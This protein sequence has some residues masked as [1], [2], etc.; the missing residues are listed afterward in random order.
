M[1]KKLQ[2]DIIRVY[3]EIVADTEHPHTPEEIDCIIAASC[4]CDISDVREVLRGHCCLGENDDE[5]ILKMHKM[6]HAIG[7]EMSTAML[8]VVPL[9]EAYEVLNEKDRMAI[10]GISILTSGIGGLS[11]GLLKAGFSKEELCTKT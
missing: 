6:E 3:G 7:L 2:E 10:C 8:D 4:D 1:T 5:P 9:D 11:S